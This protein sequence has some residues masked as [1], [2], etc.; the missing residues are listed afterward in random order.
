MP[1]SGGAVAPQLQ[2]RTATESSSMF[3]CSPCLWCVVT[4]WYW[5]RQSVIPALQWY[6]WSWWMKL[7]FLRV[8]STLYMDSMKVCCCCRSS[9][10]VV[11]ETRGPTKFIIYRV[12]QKNDPTCFYHNFIKSSPNSIIFGTQ[13]VSTIKLCEVHS[14]SISHNLCQCTAM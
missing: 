4:Q 1:K 10:V 7:A 8:L 2:A 3:R 14:L 6:W 11:S 12:G 13:I 9:L 5:S